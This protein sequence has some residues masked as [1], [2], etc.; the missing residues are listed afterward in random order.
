[1]KDPDEVQPPGGDRFLVVLCVE[2]LRDCIPFAVLDDLPLDIRDSPG[3]MPKVNE[4]LK[5]GIAGV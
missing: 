2:N 4:V 5:A 1:V 3:I